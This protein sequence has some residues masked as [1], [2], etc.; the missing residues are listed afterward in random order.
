MSY[1]CNECGKTFESNCAIGGHVN[2]AH[3]REEP[4]NT[5]NPNFEKKDELAYLAGIIVGDGFT[6][7]NKK[8][9]YVIGLESKDKAFVESFAKCLENLALNPNIC[10]R[11]RRNHT[12]M[13]ICHSRSK[14]LLEWCEALSPNEIRN[15]LEDSEGRIKL[16]LKGFYESEGHVQRETRQLGITNANE[17]LINLWI[18]LCRKIGYEFNKTLHSP[19]KEPSGGN[20]FQALIYGRQKI[21]DFFSFFI[22]LY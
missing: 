3:K 19:K 11:E 14:K 9:N 16:Y 6:A 7:R 21:E 1:I 20:P 17:E 13:W 10:Y 22:S 5:I 2:S 8:R 18:G 4:A 12:N 15:L